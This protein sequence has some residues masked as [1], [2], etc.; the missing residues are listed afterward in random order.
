MPL[1]DKN[2]E[3]ARNVL[4]RFL[5]AWSRRAF[6]TMASL[7]QVNPLDEAKFTAMLEPMLARRHLET[8]GLD[9]VVDKAHGEALAHS[10]FAKVEKEFIAFVDFRVTATISGKREGMVL[11]VVYDGKNWR[12]NHHTMARRF[13]PKED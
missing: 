10:P 12:V 9:L 13:D 6:G 8:V 7:L 5:S 3:D 11:R 4:M 2:I 1:S